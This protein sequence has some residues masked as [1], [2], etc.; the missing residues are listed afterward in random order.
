MDLLNKCKQIPMKLLTVLTLTWEI[1]KA[2]LP[3]YALFAFVHDSAIMLNIR[4][5]LQILLLL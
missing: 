3:L 1:R 2:T 5:R 4:N